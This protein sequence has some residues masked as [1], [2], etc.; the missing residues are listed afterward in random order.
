[1][2]LLAHQLGHKVTTSGAAA[3][4][5]YNTKRL[6]YYPAHR[7]KLISHGTLFRRLVWSFS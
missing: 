7:R 6:N 1:M 4:V 5:V 3:A 2:I